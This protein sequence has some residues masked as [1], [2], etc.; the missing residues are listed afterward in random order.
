V[1]QDFAALGELIMQ[2]VLVSVEEP[3][4]VTEDTPIATHLIVRQSTHAVDRAETPAD[5]KPHAGAGR[6]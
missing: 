5:P 4:S 1:R 6:A 2:K 3:D